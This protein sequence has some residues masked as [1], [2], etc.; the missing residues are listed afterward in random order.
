MDEQENALT[1]VRR[2]MSQH[3]RITAF[4]HQKLNAMG[5]RNRTVSTRFESMGSA[6]RSDPRVSHTARNYIQNFM[7]NPVA[8][9]HAMRSHSG[10]SSGHLTQHLGLPAPRNATETAQHIHFIKQLDAAVKS[11]RGSHDIQK[12]H[13]VGFQL[14]PTYNNNYRNAS[15]RV[16]HMIERTVSNS[17]YLNGPDSFAQT[18]TMARYALAHSHNAVALNNDFLAK[19]NADQGIDPL[20]PPP[21]HYS[22]AF[23]S[24][25]YRDQNNPTPPINAGMTQQGLK[26]GH[27]SSWEDGGN[28]SGNISIGNNAGS[29]PSTPGSHHSVVSFFSM[30]PGSHSSTETESTETETDT[31]SQSSASARAQSPAPSLHGGSAPPS[32]QHAAGSRP[33]SPAQH[34]SPQH[35]QFAADQAEYEQ[36]IR[37]AMVNAIQEY[38]AD[39]PKKVP[40]TFRA[41]TI[42]GLEPTAEMRA[43]F[44]EVFGGGSASPPKP[45]TPPRAPSPVK[46]ATPPKP[47]SPPPKPPSPPPKPPSPPPKPPSPPKPATPPKPPAPP[48][49]AT[50]VQPLPTSPPK[51][52]SPLKPAE[53]VAPIPEAAPPVKEPEPTAAPA[54][55]VQP[56]PPAPPGPAAASE[57]VK[58]PAAEQAEKTFREK[59]EADAH[60]A[61]KKF[62]Y[63][64]AMTEFPNV[65]R[66]Y[67]EAGLP[68]IRP[69]SPP[70]PAPPPGPKPATPPT[71]RHLPAAPLS[72]KRPAEAETETPKSRTL[73]GIRLES[74]LTDPRTIPKP[75]PPPTPKPVPPPTPKPAASS[76]T[77]GRASKAIA[78]TPQHSVAAPPATPIQ[79]PPPSPAPSTVK[80]TSP[81]STTTH[82]IAPMSTGPDRPVTHED[83]EMF[84]PLMEAAQTASMRKTMKN[85][86]HSPQV[87][88]V[89][90][91]LPTSVASKIEKMA[92]STMEMFSPTRPT[93]AGQKKSVEAKMQA[94]LEESR[95][96]A[97]KYRAEYHTAINDVEKTR[98]T[99]ELSMLR[100]IM[101]KQE[102]KSRDLAALRRR[103]NATHILGHKPSAAEAAELGALTKEFA[104]IAKDQYN[105]EILVKTTGT[106][107]D[108]DSH[109]RVLAAQRNLIQAQL[110]EAHLREAVSER[111]G[112]I[113]GEAAQARITLQHLEGQMAQEA[114]RMR[115]SAPTPAAKPPT[116]PRS[117]SELGLPSL[118]AADISMQTQLSPLRPSREIRPGSRAGAPTITIETPP[119]SANTSAES[120]ASQPRPVSPPTGPADFTLGTIPESPEGPEAQGPDYSMAV[121]NLGRLSHDND[122]AVNTMMNLSRHQVSAIDHVIQ[123]AQKRFSEYAN[124]RSTMARSQARLRELEDFKNN[125]MIPLSETL[126]ER[127]NLHQTLWSQPAIHPPEN[128][129]ENYL[130]SHGGVHEIDLPPE[131][132]ERLRS[133][134]DTYLFQN[135]K[136][137]YVMGIRD[138]TNDHVIKPLEPSLL[139]SVRAE[140]VDA[141]ASANYNPK[142]QHI[143][144]SMAEPH[145]IARAL[146][147][148][149]PGP[150]NED[151]REYNDMAV[152]HKALIY[153]IHELLRKNTRGGMRLMDQF[154]AETLFAEVQRLHATASREYDQIH[155]M[156][157]PPE[158]NHPYAKARGRD[159][160]ELHLRETYPGGSPA[161]VQ[162]LG[163]YLLMHLADPAQ[164]INNPTI[165]SDY[166][167]RHGIP[168]DY[169]LG[170]WTPADAAEYERIQDATNKRAK[171]QLDSFQLDANGAYSTTPA[172][173][174]WDALNTAHQAWDNYKEE[175]LRARYG[176]PMDYHVAHGRFHMLR[177]EAAKDRP[178]FPQLS[179]YF[180]SRKD[181]IL[182]IIKEQT[183]PIWGTERATDLPHDLIPPQNLNPKPLKAPTYFEQVVEGVYERHDPANQLAGAVELNDPDPKFAIH[184]YMRSRFPQDFLSQVHSPHQR[185][186]HEYIHR[187]MGVTQD[188]L[189][190][191]LDRFNMDIN[192]I[193]KIGQKIYEH[194]KT[195]EA[196]RDIDKPTRERP[197]RFDPISIIKSIRESLDQVM[198]MPSYV[199]ADPHDFGTYEFPLFPPTVIQNLRQVRANAAVLE[200]NANDPQIMEALKAGL[201][202]R[203]VPE[204]SAMDTT[205]DSPEGQGFGLPP[206]SLRHR[207]KYDR[208]P[209]H[210]PSRNYQNLLHMG[211]LPRTLTTEILELLGGDLHTSHFLRMDKSSMTATVNELNQ[212]K[213]LSRLAKMAPHQ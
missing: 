143:Y 7:N 13:D 132:D 35:N 29:P 107:R 212:G 98:P 1:S 176:N 97:E 11:S 20:K 113:F 75:A 45:K 178:D 177:P 91:G 82:V 5:I 24:Q 186:L 133:L 174:A 196:L 139:M 99:S 69:P 171:Y 33:P 54:A 126:A 122:P 156:H 131:A 53:P 162:D 104:E 30:G 155:R 77:P 111:G 190:D 149:P 19:L 179:A 150:D 140:L 152:L 102:A 185:R 138:P 184:D 127:A 86:L 211:N 203:Q 169:G 70:T 191:D 134:L 85:L 87:K 180:G 93:F 66:M 124:T 164:R 163:D 68:P 57:R 9:F 55:E 89:T 28:A 18:N 135:K 153:R 110:K 63:H 148:L 118:K 145:G 197:Q 81:L 121:R 144:P 123:G 83:P 147:P 16:S 159:V 48:K 141:M 49:P 37:E 142:I 26:P 183:K 47:P 129:P 193:N 194:G 6:L 76:S 168:V 51:E 17:D 96:E 158:S 34:W 21:P 58:H 209:M 32:P 12:L 114:E 65:F 56:P 161:L 151:A 61:I 198:T 84:N 39:A 165:V 22:S 64:K 36:G 106:S 3:H 2:H 116:P 192:S 94:A 79:A 117:L 101:E 4:I 202:N 10:G 67:D 207:L 154:A 43:L 8:G 25:V 120:A 103:F 90:H 38:G 78:P 23:I 41:Y 74:V 210:P 175:A 136:G 115:L 44:P 172:H 72:Q 187:N 31:T 42:S 95:K 206:V 119:S 188:E 208:A 130:M 146:I 157:F 80:R 213:T 200:Q 182:P 170:Q 166:S 204:Q 201:G 137:R 60:L 112:Q 100:N 92:E 105:L 15:S 59:L 167:S 205:A 62:G 195:A 50:P 40:G 181:N 199:S 71:G 173:A 14:D 27:V 88:Q 125:T 52:P 109:F 108:R 128:W 189:S 46:A 73:K 160:M